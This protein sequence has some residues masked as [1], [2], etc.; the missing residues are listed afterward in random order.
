[1]FRNYFKTAWRNLINNKVYS[2]LNILGLATGMGVALII[3]LWV[4]YQYAYDKF[5]PGY[6]D[7]YQVYYRTTDKNEKHTQNSVCYPLAD[8][9][10]K[11]I[12]G[13][14]YVARTDWVGSHGLVVGNN[15]IY[16][17]GAMAGS[18]FLRIFQY[19]LI[20]GNAANVLKDPYSIVLTQSTA[21]ALF[22]NEDPINKVVRI[23]NTSNL[24]VSGVL[25]DVPKNSTLQFK[26]L[27]PFDYFMLNG[28]FGKDWGNNSYQTF[29]ALQPNV[30]YAQ[31]EPK[32]KYLLKQYDAKDYAIDKGEVFMHP[33]TSWHLYNDFKNGIASGG[34]IDY[35]RMFGI[36]GLLVLCIACINF[37]NLSTA[38][39]GKR[40]REVGI[41]KAVGSQRS[42]LVFQF[43]IES[44]VITFAAFL[45]SILFVQLALPAFNA[46]TQA[47]IHIPYGNLFFWCIMIGY[48]LMTGLLAGSRPAFYLSSFNAIK[49]L[50]GTINA[51]SK[52]SLPRKILVT[53]QFSCSVALIISTVIVYQQIQ[54]AK[55][56][57]AGYDAN[58]LMM[59]DVSPDL[60]KNYEA[61]KNEMLQSGVVS[62]VTKASCPVTELWS[63]NFINDWQGKQA[64]ERL[65]AG[66]IAVSDVDYF[67]TLGM[68]LAEGRNFTGSIGADSLSMIINEAAA[69][70]MHFKQPVGQ[71]V[72]W[73]Q[74]AQRATVIGVVKNALMTSPFSNDAPTYFMFQPDNASSIMYRLSPTVNAHDAVTKLTSIFNKYNPAYPYLYR[75]VDESYTAKFQF[76]NLVGKLAGLFAALAIFISCLG[77]FGLAAYMAEQRTKEI[78]IRKVLGASVPQVWLLLSKEFIVL[79]LVSCV[80]ASPVAFYYLNNWLQQ[81]D[82]R[83]TISPVVF[84]IAGIAAVLITIITVSFQAIKAAIANPV[85]SLRTE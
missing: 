4:Y 9:L 45:C 34:L 42:S 14:K 8:V 82:Y 54:Y 15:K 53:L 72:D 25:K 29:V 56:R 69:K 27:V 16:E 43:L 7:V 48:V 21:K 37:M 22:G 60:Q 58:R 26:Y 80:I 24:K 83:I 50:K 55:N 2:A 32:I 12:P 28:G 30:S 52:A 65:V 73:G 18:D 38:R 66:T 70:R 84:I 5:L 71:S 63:W 6:K 64:D 39:S 85:K 81:Y 57:P 35:V 19:D 44:L 41:R 61:L 40:A 13:I 23:D 17:N 47:D 77:L 46:L 59:T 79:V 20:K 10:Q 49:V 67:K 74:T 75:F 62:G 11:D 78:G 76:E 1:M 3:G 68:Q 36:I 33:L 51:G 31:V